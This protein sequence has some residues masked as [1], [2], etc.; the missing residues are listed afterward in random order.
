MRF[1]IVC[2]Y[3]EHETINAIH[4]FCIHSGI[5]TI[6]FWK[7]MEEISTFPPTEMVFTW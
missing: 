4:L 2:D 5:L 1:G 3:T 6:E 7:A